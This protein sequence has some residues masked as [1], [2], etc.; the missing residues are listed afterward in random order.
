MAGY[1][2]NMNF[3]VP[4]INQCGKK[5]L[6]YKVRHK[7]Y[8]RPLAFIVRKNPNSIKNRLQ[9]KVIFGFEKLVNY[10]QGKCDKTIPRPSSTSSVG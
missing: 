8:A 9:R 10:D 7:A 2:M 5:D 3:L 4:N 1:T 6:S